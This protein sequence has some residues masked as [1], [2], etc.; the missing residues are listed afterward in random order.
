MSV[1]DASLHILFPSLLLLSDKHCKGYDLKLSNYIAITNSR[2]ITN[3]N[4][5]I[6][7]WASLGSL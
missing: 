1:Y 7:I 4:A 5:C 2:L 3:A 6:H